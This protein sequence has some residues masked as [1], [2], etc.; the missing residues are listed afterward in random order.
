MPSYEDLRDIVIGKLVDRTIDEDY[1]ELSERLFG[2]GNCYSSS[3]C[4]KRMYG[5][6]TIIEAI[7]RDGRKSIQDKNAISELDEK[8]I[9]LMRERQQFFDQRR[10]YN[11]LVN[12]DGRIEHLYKT[13]EDAANRLGETVGKVYA[14]ESNASHIGTGESDAVMVFSDWHYGLVADNAFNRFNTEVCRQ[15]VKSATEQAIQRILLHNC[16]RL[17]IVVLG[18]LWHGAIHT[19][20]RVASEELVCDQMMQVTEILAQTIEEL[21]QYVDETIVYVTYGNHART[22]QNKK[23]N[24]HRDNMERIVPWWLTQRLS[25]YENVIIAEDSGNEFLFINACGHNIVACHGDLD[26]VKSSPRLLSVLFQKQFG[27]NIEYIILGD[28]HHIESFEEFGVCATICGSLCGTDDYANGKR[29][30]STPSQLLLIVT[31]KYGVDAEYK[32]KLT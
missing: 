2:E 7:E 26:S 16:G 4:R 29:L 32:I 12:R 15:R 14:K 1:E 20:A 27:K 21:S 17:H 3:E 11:K 28:Q 9:A 19:S 8:R 31:P 13:L 25:R 6:K 18:D 30:F 23:D 22:V 5:M 10:E 24:I